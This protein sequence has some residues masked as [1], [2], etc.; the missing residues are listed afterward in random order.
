MHESERHRVILAALRTSPMATVAALV[1][2][3]GTSEATVRRD[4]AA[5][6]AKGRLQRV[7]GGAKA[8][9]Y[10]SPYDALA[11]AQEVAPT[12][13][14]AAKHAIARKAASLCNDGESIIIN[15]GS[16]TYQL[17]NH[18]I[19]RRMQVLT[20]SFPIADALLSFSESTVFVPGG[21]INRDSKIIASPFDDDGVAGFS[22]LRMFTSCA[23]IGP[24]GLMETD[25]VLIQAERR[26]MRQADEIVVMADS[27]KF[28]RVQQGL[29]M[30]SFEGVDTLITDNQIREEQ[31]R[32][33]EHAGVSVLVVRISARAERT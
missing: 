13:H 24:H 18:L 31:L 2:L 10:P 4:I 9:E 30:S 27:T 1:E 8:I 16:T 28:A 17:V 12:L 29:V 3:T 14:L 15:G 21:M 19:S 33:L 26:L 6:E 25:P 20:N 23:G 11:D 22:A 5:L 32:M 7:W